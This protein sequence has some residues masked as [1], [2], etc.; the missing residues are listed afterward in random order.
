MKHRRQVF[1]LF[2]IASNLLSQHQDHASES[3]KL[4]AKPPA[5]MSGLGRTHHRISTRNPDTQRFFDQGLSLVYAFNR[6]EAVRSFQRAAELD[7]KCAMPYWG[8]AIAQGPTINNPQLSVAREKIA[9]EAVQRALSLAQAAPAQEQAYI[10]A[11]AKRYSIDPNADQKKLALDY[12]TEMERV[13]KRYPNDLDAATLYAESAMDLHPWQLWSRDGRATEGTEEILA[14]LRSVLARNPTHIGA[15]HFYIHAVEASP[16]PRQGVASARRLATLTPAAGHLLHMP[17]HIYMRTGDYDAAALSNEAAAA[18]DRAYI[19]AYKVTGSYPLSYYTHNLHFLAIARS[20]EGN[21]GRAMKAVDDLEA[22]IGPRLKD[23][24]PGFFNM[25]MPTRELILVRFR[26][27]DDISNLPE[28]PQSMLLT[29]CLWHFAR[30]MASGA[31][32]DLAGAEAERSAFIEAVKVVP[33]SASFDLNSGSSVLKVAGF[34]LDSRIAV[35]R[36]EVAAALDALRKAVDAD[37][38]LVYDEPPSWSL[39][40]RECLGGVLML[41]GEHG[42]AEKVFRDD[43]QRNPKNGR[44][45]FGLFQSLKAQGDAAGSKKVQREFESAWE[46]ADTRLTLDDL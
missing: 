14:V 9:Y 43:L 3:A 25:F 21:F 42:Q 33:E 37:D 5:L 10:N 39:P 8:I 2:L 22:A 38:A 35:A 4:P 1:L 46:T 16:N 41:A 32:G 24:P 19:E 40:A 15:N 18:A 27:W 20:M 45:L 30:G 6:D 11:L 29:R 12:K 17:A 31:T 34:M 13:A 7:P 26:R 28:P 23:A 36:R 44:S